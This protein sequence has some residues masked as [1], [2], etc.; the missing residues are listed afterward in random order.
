MAISFSTFLKVA[1]HIM[2]AKHP[3]ALRAWHGVGKSELIGQLAEIFKL[4]VTGVVMRRVSQ[5]A[6]AGDLVGLPK[7]DG[8][9]TT[10][11]AMDWL[12]R[13]CTE[14]VILFFDEFDRANEEILQALMELTDSRC[15]YGRCLHPGTL[16][17]GACNGG[18][19]AAEHYKGSTLDP[20]QMDRWVVFD[21]EPTI[22]EWAAWGKQHP[23]R[24]HPL[25][26]E[27]VT[28]DEGREN[29]EHRG[30][31][32]PQMIYP[33]R[34]SW[35]RLSE[36]LIGGDL[37]SDISDK[38]ML[39]IIYEVAKGYI[40]Q[41][42]AIAFQAFLADY[43]SRVSVADIFAE[44]FDKLSRLQPLQHTRLVKQLEDGYYAKINDKH[45]AALAQYFVMVPAE[46]AMSI[47]AALVKQN[48]PASRTFYQQKVA[49]HSIS[50]HVADICRGGRLLANK[51]KK[52][53]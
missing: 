13:A 39:Q 33:S 7:M 46:L 37:L 32:D 49:G 24:M 26:L 19:A 22:D 45:L 48:M 27:Y 17:F 23:E 16:I 5:M 15:L 21:V 43:Q 8:E 34:R 31:Y 20:A 36:C 47:W 1:P 29:V 14:P 4:E 28:S 40:G 44:R 38:S 18:Q 35:T 53:V 12:H 2:R 6:D 42:A 50:E 10:F 25:V 11:L 30:V 9:W 52:D 3:I 51:G 41:Y